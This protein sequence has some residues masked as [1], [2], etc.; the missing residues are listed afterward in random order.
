[1]MNRTRIFTAGPS[2][3]VWLVGL[4]LGLMFLH[5]CGADP[6]PKLNPAQ[7]AFKKAALALIARETKELMPLLDRPNP[8]PALQANID[9]QFVQGLK[10]GKPIDHD[11]AVLGP[12]AVVLAW[13][14]PDPEDL[15]KTHVGVVGQNYSKFTKL[16]PVYQSGLIAGFEVFTQYGPGLGLCSPMRQGSNLK[17]V[18]CLGYDEDTLIR[19]YDMDKEQFLEINFNQ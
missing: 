4:L 15:S 8:V 9:Q 14:T 18:L 17:G 11:L 16:N 10:K 2:G 5:A 13:R 3:V 7:D 6:A 1:M 19:R 12:D